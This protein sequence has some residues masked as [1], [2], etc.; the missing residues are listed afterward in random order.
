M[1]N[2]FS[3]FS[4]CCA[5]RSVLLS[6]VNKS[7]SSSPSDSPYCVSYCTM[8]YKTKRK[9]DH[10]TSSCMRTSHALGPESFFFRSYG[11]KLKKNH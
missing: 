10:Q 5:M 4:S 8:M 1:A 7:S 11:S 2:S 3:R 9:E 6:Q